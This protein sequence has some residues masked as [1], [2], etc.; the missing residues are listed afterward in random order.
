MGQLILS[1]DELRA[2]DRRHHFHPFTDNKALWEEGGGTRVITRG[3]GVY[4]YDAEGNRILDAFAGL[5]CVALG[6]GRK[7]LAEA[8]YQQMQELPFYNTFFKCTTPRVTELSAAIAELTPPGLDRV[9]FATSGSEAN[10]TIVKA[11]RHFW[12]LHGKPTKKH[13]IGRT[14]GYH[15]STMATTSLGGMAEM[16][17]H[18][19]LPL[20]G[21]AHIKPPYWYRFGGDMDPKDYGVVAARELEK[22]IQQLGPDNVAAFIGEPIMGA[23]GVMLP[24]ETYWPEINRIC[25]QYDVLLIADEVVCGFGRTGEWFGTQLYGIE[26]DVMTLGKQ[27]TSAYLPL[28]AVVMGPR[29]RETMHEKGGE[30]RH[31]FTYSG[32]P[33][34]CAVAL[35]TIRILKDEKIVERVKNDTGPYL[36]K[37]LQELADHP[38]VGEVRGV[39]LIAGV[40]LV[41][42]KK[43]R[44]P[45]RP[46]GHAGITLRDHCLKNGLILRATRDSMLFSPPLTITR[47]EID[48]VIEITKK[49][50]DLAAKDLKS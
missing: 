10:E 18:G 30:F 33:V 6:Y 26:P 16:H 19:D 8:A 13:F 2:L 35:E 14:Y 17:E 1:V 48:E 49:G 20:P 25:K 7:E 29:M 39:G 43:T 11:I 12:N 31:G 42:D 3:E 9:F 22:K 40:E 50:L 32:H 38:L 37:R 46:E 36:Q 15:G 28:S 21:F 41:A 24:P 4:I 5:W 47:D 45:F 44:Q 23:G 34:S 27:I